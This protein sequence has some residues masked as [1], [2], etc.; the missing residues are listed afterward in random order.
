MYKKT[1]SMHSQN[2]DTI[3]ISQ[4]MQIQLYHDSITTLSVS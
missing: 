1:G 4:I 2:M 3:D